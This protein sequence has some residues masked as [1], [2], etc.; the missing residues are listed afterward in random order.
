MQYSACAEVPICIIVHVSLDVSLAI[1]GVKFL[2]SL[3]LW[4]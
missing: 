1:A 4:L 2:F 3:S